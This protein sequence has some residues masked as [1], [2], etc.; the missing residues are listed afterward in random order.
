MG[1]SFSLHLVI[2]SFNQ[3]FT[4]TYSISYSCLNLYSYN[5]FAFFF[6]LRQA[7]SAA[8]AKGHTKIVA[9][10]LQVK[11]IDVNQGVCSSYHITSFSYYL[12]LPIFFRVLPLPYAISLL[13]LRS[14]IIFCYY[15]C[16]CFSFLYRIHFKPRQQ[17]A[18]LKW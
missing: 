7:L 9:M 10:L 5:C 3:S 6:L 14:L 11:G 13:Y 15:Y 17:K 8:A 1:T 4:P 18:T 2:S 12:I 16:Y